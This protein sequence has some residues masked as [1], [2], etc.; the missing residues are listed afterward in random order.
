MFWQICFSND[1]RYWSQLI[2]MRC[3]MA[4][5]T[6]ELASQRGDSKCYPRQ[7]DRW[8]EG[9]MEDH[10]LP[11]MWKWNKCVVWKVVR[12]MHEVWLFLILCSWKYVPCICPQS[13]EVYFKELAPD[14]GKKTAWM[15][16]VG[17]TLKDCK[18]CVP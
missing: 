8:C 17:I 15:A 5:D 18:L 9:L 12:L 16:L 3:S 13:A 11:M 2:C 6:Q 1:Y 4:V 7:Q 10:F 14:H